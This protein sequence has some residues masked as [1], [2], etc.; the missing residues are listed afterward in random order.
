MVTKFFG[1]SN[2]SDFLGIKPEI[3]HRYEQIYLNDILD[4]WRVPA[5][6]VKPLSDDHNVS[7]V[8]SSVI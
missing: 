3:N 8:E 6:T 5:L 2:F 4:R 7:Q 1:N